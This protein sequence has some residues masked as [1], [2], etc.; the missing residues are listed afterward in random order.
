MR[1]ADWTYYT[2]LDGA[3][4][5]SGTAAKITFRDYGYVPLHLVQHAETVLRRSKQL[6]RRPGDNGAG[7]VPVL[8]QGEPRNVDQ[9]GPVNWRMMLKDPV[10]GGIMDDYFQGPTKCQAAICATFD[11][12][13]I[14]DNF[15][16]T[17]VQKFCEVPV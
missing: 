5:L 12:S 1:L 10:L 2:E 11:E 17:A 9:A 6:F 16:K 15:Y 7:Q 4:G 3:G 8:V 14:L 13:T